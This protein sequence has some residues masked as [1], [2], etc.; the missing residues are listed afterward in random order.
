MINSSKPN[1]PFSLNAVISLSLLFSMHVLLSAKIY[2]TDHIMIYSRPV[3]LKL[4]VATRDWVAGMVKMRN[5]VAKRLATQLIFSKFLIAP[6][7]P[8]GLRTTGLGYAYI[9]KNYLKLPKL[10]VATEQQHN[11][12]KQSAVQR[13]EYN[14]CI[15][16][17]VTWSC[18]VSTNSLRK[19]IQ[20]SL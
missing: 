10:Q 6:S 19:F 18:Y 2:K 15:L 8:L 13:Y 7:I 1:F 9:W 20:L 4:W 11:L 12:N 3:F 16:C 14:Y 5:Q 17:R